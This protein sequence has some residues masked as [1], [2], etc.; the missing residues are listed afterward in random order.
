MLR[1]STKRSSGGSLRQVC[2]PSHASRRRAKRRHSCQVPE[3]M[4]GSTSGIDGEQLV[5]RFHRADGR[6]ILLVEFERIHE[7]PPGV[8]PAGR[9]HHHLEKISKSRGNRIG[10]YF[11]VEFSPQMYDLPRNTPHESSIWLRPPPPFIL[12]RTLD[13]GTVVLPDLDRILSLPRV[14]HPPIVVVICR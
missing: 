7:I 3:K 1:R 8:A 14:L 5:D 11:G 10:V 9:M 6:G 12:F 13:S 2:K 4:P